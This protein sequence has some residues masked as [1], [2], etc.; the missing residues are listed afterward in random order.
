MNEASFTHPANRGIVC[1]A[2]QQA[3]MSPKRITSGRRK[4][5]EKRQDD[6]GRRERD[7]RIIQVSWEGRGG[8][9]G[10][11]SQPTSAQGLG[12]SDEEG[13]CT[14]SPSGVRSLH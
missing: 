10:E 2:L 11:G 1:V 14:T 5:D 9:K 6:G 4:G 12:G 8:K 3:V 7:N 13:L